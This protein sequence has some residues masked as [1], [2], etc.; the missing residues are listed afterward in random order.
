MKDSIRGKEKGKKLN[1]TP[2]PQA[3]KKCF[4]VLMQLIL[5]GY[6]E[7]HFKKCPKEKSKEII[8]THRTVF[9]KEE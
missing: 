6:H 2:K 8:C 4:L 7:I 1:I 3:K 5:R 9:P